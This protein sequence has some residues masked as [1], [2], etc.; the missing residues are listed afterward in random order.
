MNEIKPHKLKPCPF[1]GNIHPSVPNYKNS[2][3]T[4]LR[5]FCEDCEANGPVAS[6]KEYAMESWNRRT[7]NE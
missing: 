3:I 7:A 4:W 1:C 2:G 5:V 6:T